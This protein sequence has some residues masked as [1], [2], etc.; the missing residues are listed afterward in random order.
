MVIRPGK[1]ECDCRGRRHPA[2]VATWSGRKYNLNNKG[3]WG[4]EHRAS[5]PELPRFGGG[6]VQRYR[7]WDAA[8]APTA[9]FRRR[10]CD[11]PLSGQLAL[12]LYERAEDGTDRSSRLIPYGSLNFFIVARV[13]VPRV[14]SCKSSDTQRRPFITRPVP[15]LSTWPELPEGKAAAS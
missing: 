10:P 14:N 1:R 5:R 2:L 13:V 11:H 15:G 6:S 3:R 4:A 12:I 9:T 7:A 8:P